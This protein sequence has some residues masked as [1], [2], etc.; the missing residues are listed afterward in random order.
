MVERIN[1]GTKRGDKYGIV[2]GKSYVKENDC[3]QVVFN[4]VNGIHQIWGIPAK[5]LSIEELIRRLEGG[6]VNFS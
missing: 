6:S 5:D 2:G 3:Y 4:T 1:G